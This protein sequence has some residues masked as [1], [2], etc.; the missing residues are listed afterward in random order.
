[1][2][3][4][5]CDIIELFIKINSRVFD[6]IY[7]V[8]HMSS[9]GTKE[10]ISALKMQGFPVEYSQLNCSQFN[11]AETITNLVRQ[12]AQL[13]LYDYIVP[14]DADEFLC[15]ESNDI[16]RWISSKSFGLIPWRTFCPISNEYYAA[17]A[18]LYVEIILR[19]IV[20]LNVSLRY[21]PHI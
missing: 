2:V 14:M 13:N 1:M 20:T 18:P 12:V 17:E 4:N 8:D 11:Q 19:K 21:F 9:D 3:R 6:A 15:I 5:E 16:S 7:I 10:I